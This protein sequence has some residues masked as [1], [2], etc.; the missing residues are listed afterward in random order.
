MLI[1]SYFSEKNFSVNTYL[2]EGILSLQE[3][4]TDLYSGSMIIL[5]LCYRNTENDLNQLKEQMVLKSKD[6]MAHLNKFQNN[7]QFISENKFVPNIIKYLYRN[8]SIYHLDSD[9][10]TKIEKEYLLRE[11][12]YFSYALNEQAEKNQDYI[13][14]NFDNNFYIL[15]FNSSQDIYKLNGY[16]EPAFNQRFFYYILMNII[17]NIK[18]ILLSILEELIIAQIKTINYYSIAFNVING[19]LII[20]LIIN[21]FFILLKNRLDGKFVKQIFIFCIIMKKMKF[22]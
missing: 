17:F 10:T 16:K 14:C 21:E 20:L 1:K 2:L 11:I 19:L 3:L 12:N 4:K 6:L 13:K 22:N 15:F 5:S 18:P 9:W 7:L 8:I